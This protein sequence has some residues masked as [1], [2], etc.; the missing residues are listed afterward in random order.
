MVGWSDYQLATV[1][2]KLSAQEPR[3]PDQ[4]ALLL[5]LA[6]ALLRRRQGGDPLET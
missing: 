2:D 5:F 6:D 3:T 4:D 1:V